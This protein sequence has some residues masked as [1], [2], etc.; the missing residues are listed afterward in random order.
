MY[1]ACMARHFQLDLAGSAAPTCYEPI[2]GE[3]HDD[4]Q[5][6]L[7]GERQRAPAVLAIGAGCGDYL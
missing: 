1:T 6:W 4:I 3:A 7:G 2:A 5:Q